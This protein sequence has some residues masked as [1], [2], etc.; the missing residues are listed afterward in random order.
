MDQQELQDEGDRSEMTY[1]NDYYT[2]QETYTLENNLG[3]VAQNDNDDCSVSQQCSSTLS[4]VSV[5]DKES[6]F[7]KILNGNSEF[8][9]NLTDP[10][11]TAA[12]SKSGSCESF[13]SI[14]RSE[15]AL[16]EICIKSG[17]SKPESLLSIETGAFTKSSLSR[18]DIDGSKQTVNASNIDNIYKSVLNTVIKTL[19]ILFN[20]I[21]C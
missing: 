3:R 11:H 5:D 6:R 10:T 2:V 13:D 21:T 4:F 16:L 20:L 17:I 12:T 14:E 19:V 18:D 8:I 9:E 1:T 15:Q 7:D